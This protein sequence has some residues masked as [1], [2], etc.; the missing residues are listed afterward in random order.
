MLTDRETHILFVCLLKDLSKIPQRRVSTLLRRR[1][2]P[3][4]KNLNPHSCVCACVCLHILRF[5]LILLLKSLFFVLI[6]ATDT[7]TSKIPLYRQKFEILFQ[8]MFMIRINSL[9]IQIIGLKFKL[10]NFHSNQINRHGSQCSSSSHHYVCD[11]FSSIHYSIIINLPFCATRYDKER[12]QSIG[13]KIKK[14]ITFI[15][16]KQTCV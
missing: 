3:L 14:K 6:L 11:F 2:R 10:Y 7:Q 13:K 5:T 8:N 12:N 4:T 9:Q 15:K 16:K 1:P